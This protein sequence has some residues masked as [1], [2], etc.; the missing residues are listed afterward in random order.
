[1]TMFRRLCLSGL[2]FILALSNAFA[3]DRRPNVLLIIAD[4]LRTE[5]GCYGSVAKTPQIDALA[6]RGVLFERTYC[7]QALCNPSRSSF[8]TGQRPDTLGLWCNGIHFRDLAP[9]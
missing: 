2:V 6:K 3:A 1:M 9:N 4:D 8:F 5:L 7:Q